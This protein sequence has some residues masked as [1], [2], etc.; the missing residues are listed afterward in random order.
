MKRDLEKRPTKETYKRDLE[1]SPTDPPDLFESAP[2]SK[3]ICTY[4]KKCIKES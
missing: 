2:T 1:K 3:E 4:D